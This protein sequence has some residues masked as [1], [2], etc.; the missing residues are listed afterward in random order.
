[1]DFQ[2]IKPTLL[3]RK[4]D[5][6]RKRNP[7][8]RYSHGLMGK[9]IGGVKSFEMCTLYQFSDLSHHQS[10]MVSNKA[11]NTCFIPIEDLPVFLSW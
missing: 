5:F 2:T 1:M 4:Q 7:L 8:L 3:R 9:F 10:F 11:P 6:L